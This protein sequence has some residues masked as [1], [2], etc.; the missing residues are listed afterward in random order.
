M[1]TLTLK[2]TKQALL[3]LYPLQIPVLL[4]GAS[5]VGKTSIVREVAEDL[6][7]PLID[8][9]LS[10]EL[11][12]NVGGIPVKSE[13]GKYFMKLFNKALAPAFD[14]GAVLFFDELNRS[15][16]WVRNAVMSAFFERTLGGRELH[17]S[18]FVIGAINRGSN[19]KDT[20]KLD[21]AMIAR[22]AIINVGTR[23]E[24]ALEYLKGKYPTGASV[25]Y[26]KADAIST[27]IYEENRFDQLTPALT[28]R[29]LEYASK[30]IETYANDPFLRKLLYTVVPSD[31]ADLMLSD[32][33]FTLIRRILNGE[34]VDMP[35][36]KASL[37]LTIIT[38]LPLNDEE[39]LNAIKYAKKV[40]SKHTVKD[41]VLGFL[42]NLARHNK[43]LFIK[44]IAD[45]NREFP[46]A[47]NSITLN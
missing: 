43:D 16:M 27:R 20:E 15:S 39:F 18:T 21:W 45:I 32:L 38:T 6:K 30:I 37:L 13:D 14:S 26:S 36:E 41:S 9:R 22:F 24:E 33:D 17:P 8:V 46:H 29:N 11:P 44:H 25:L 2:E 28:Y 23:M 31:I 35:Y 34:D 12:E 40:Y 19:Y 7:L 47:K 1:A 42:V 3:K 5:G 10:T 4:N